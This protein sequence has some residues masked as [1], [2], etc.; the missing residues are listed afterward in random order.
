MPGRETRPEA[1]RRR[2]SRTCC[3]GKGRPVICGRDR[4]RRTT[5]TYYRGSPGRCPNTCCPRML[6]LRRGTSLHPVPATQTAVL[7][8]VGR[9]TGEIVR[10]CPRCGPEYVERAFSRRPR[11]ARSEHRKKALHSGLTEESQGQWTPDGGRAAGTRPESRK[12]RQS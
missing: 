3:C 1:T 4:A 6:E 5:P 7:F 11:P 12:T 2:S 9:Q 8:W 10:T